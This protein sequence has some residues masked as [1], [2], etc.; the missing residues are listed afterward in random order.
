MPEDVN[1][2]LGAANIQDRFEIS[3]YTLN[4][5]SKSNTEEVPFPGNISPEGYFYSPFH[6]IM[7]R[8]LDDVV[9]SS[10]V[11]RINFV[12]AAASAT[13]ATTVF[14]NPD[15]GSSAETDV[16]IVK[17]TTPVNY[18]FI[19]NQPFCIYDVLCGLTYWGYF[20]GMTGREINILTKESID[21]DGLTGNAEGSGG[22]SRYIISYLTENVP[23]YAEFIPTNQRLVWRAPKKM[24]ELENTSPIYNMPFTNGRLYIHK[25]VN[26][27]VRRQDPQEEY[28]VSKPS[29]LNP[30]NRFKVPGNKKIDFDYVREINDSLTDAC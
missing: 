28:S 26:V 14:Y 7:L 25:N 15:D 4:M 20:S 3:S 5:I 10:E 16:N 23:E 22:K 27:F 2:Q 19:N 9:E 30:L 6:E 18:G 13:T 12:P 11:R 29:V 24:S 1:I 17:I 8:E 21:S